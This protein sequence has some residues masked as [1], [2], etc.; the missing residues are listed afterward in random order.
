MRIPFN[1]GTIIYILVFELRIKT[2][3]Q[4]G[5]WVYNKLYF[6]VIIYNWEKPEAGQVV[7]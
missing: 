2:D 6:S 4:C 7:F 5:L 3:T 1:F